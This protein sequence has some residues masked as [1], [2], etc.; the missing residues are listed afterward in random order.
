MTIDISNL[1]A[2]LLEAIL[3]LIVRENVQ[4][5]SCALDDPRLW[6]RLVEEQLTRSERTGLSRQHAFSL[7]GPENLSDVPWEEWG[8]DVHIPY[9]GVYGA[10]LLIPPPRDFC[11]DADAE[12]G[13]LSS[14]VWHWGE[15]AECGYVCHYLL[16]LQDLGD[17]RCASRRELGDGWILYESNRPYTPNMLFKDG[18][19]GES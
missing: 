16:T 9:E 11:T 10:D 19:G 2:P 12:G 3:D 8:G 13:S 7:S 6:R 4:S 17:L 1:P 18:G 14:V 15:D 5:V